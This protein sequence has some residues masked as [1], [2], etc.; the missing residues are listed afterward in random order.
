MEIGF[1]RFHD[2]YDKQ[3]LGGSFSI[4]FA[5]DSIITLYGWCGLISC[6]YTFEIFLR[7][8]H[9]HS[10]RACALFY[11]D[12]FVTAWAHRKDRKTLAAYLILNSQLYGVDSK[13]FTAGE[14]SSQIRILCEKCCQFYAALLT[15]A[16]NWSLIVSYHFNFQ[17]C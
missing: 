16:K 14:I 8:F 17:T 12:Y 7:I 10:V 5:K 2:Y 1:V 6:I 4:W 13:T 9:L 11:R 15:E 3:N